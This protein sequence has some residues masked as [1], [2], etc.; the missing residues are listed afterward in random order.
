M[1]LRRTLTDITSQEN[2]GKALRSKKGLKRGENK[3]S[4]HYDDPFK[5]TIYI[6][7][8]DHIHPSHKITLQKK[9]LAAPCG[10]GFVK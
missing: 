1:L 3:Q 9:P 8:L 4:G 10:Y 5:L 2:I 6:I 7:V